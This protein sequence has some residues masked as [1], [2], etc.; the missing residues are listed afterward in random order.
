MASTDRIHRSGSSATVPVV[1]LL[2]DTEAL[3]ALIR[4]HR[5]GGSAAVPIVILS[6]D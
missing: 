2:D 4:I 3:A 6:D 1:I 5:S